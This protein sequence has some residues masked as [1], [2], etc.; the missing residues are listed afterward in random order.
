MAL[1]VVDKSGRHI[2]FVAKKYNNN[3]DILMAALTSKV[4]DNN[5][6]DFEEIENYLSSCYNCRTIFG[7]INKSKFDNLIEQFLIGEYSKLAPIGRENFLRFLLMK[8]PAKLEELINF[9]EKDDGVYGYILIDTNHISINNDSIIIEDLLDY[10]GGENP[11]K[12]IP[13]F[14]KVIHYPT[15]YM[16][17]E[18]IGEGILIKDGFNIGL[19]SHLH[20]TRVK[21]LSGNYKYEIEIPMQI[22]VKKGMDFKT[23]V[24]D[25]MMKCVFA[26][27]VIYRF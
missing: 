3:E 24:K 15:V 1:N 13:V 4:I 27:G 22:M 11:L 12:A 18:S 14:N 10:I 21:L 7:K 16:D 9:N 8:N 25:D 6:L 20:G 17:A 2:G 26:D 23:Y 19:K 5:L